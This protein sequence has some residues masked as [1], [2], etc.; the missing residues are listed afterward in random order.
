MAA[1]KQW[2]VHCIRTDPKAAKEEEIVITTDV[3]I[4][5]AGT[6]GSSEILL[7]SRERGLGM[8]GQVGLHFGT[9]G[10]FF[11]VGYNAEAE[12]GGLGFGAGPSSKARQAKEG[13]SGPCITS[14]LD[15]RDPSKPARQGMIVEDMAV[16]SAFADTISVL[17]STLAAASGEPTDPDWKKGG[18]AKAAARQAKDVAE[19]PW[20]KGGAMANSIMYGCM[21]FDDQAG[22]L[23]LED[24]KKNLTMYLLCGKHVFTKIKTNSNIKPITHQKIQINTKPKT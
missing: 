19:G 21:S 3:L 10:D 12:W 23:A 20:A 14:V 9:D 24:P 15:M 22:L 6:L 8:S 18:R 13:D 1:E 17:F 7:R 2:R 4:L 5:A 11:S 16:P